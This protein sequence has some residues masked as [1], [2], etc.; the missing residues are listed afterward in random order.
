MVGHLPILCY[1]LPLDNIEQQ[2]HV[3]KQ[4]LLAASD[5]VPYLAKRLVE[6]VMH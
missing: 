6:Q 4:A 1:R 2:A 5:P 3:A